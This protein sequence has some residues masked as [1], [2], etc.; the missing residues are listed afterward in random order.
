MSRLPHLAAARADHGPDAPTSATA[1]E[2]RRRASDDQTTMPSPRR[3]ALARLLPDYWQRFDAVRANYLGDAASNPERGAR[4]CRGRRIRPPGPRTA[5]PS[6]RPRL[7]D[8]RPPAPRGSRRPPARGASGH[9]LP[10]ATLAR[11]PA[12]HQPRPGACAVR[13]WPRRLPPG[14][15]RDG[16]GQ[17]IHQV[18][19]LLVQHVLDRIHET[20]PAL[21]ASPINIL[22][23]S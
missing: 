11:R 9:S 17:P 14:S 18:R 20:P 22:N 4:G 16:R 6:L 1:S 5:R 15:R 19:Q 10:A 21:S 8:A 12:G 7:T 13:D 3:S 23:I 2:P